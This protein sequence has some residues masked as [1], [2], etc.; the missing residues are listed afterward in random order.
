MEDLESRCADL[1][2][3]IEEEKIEQPQLTREQLTFWLERFRS[4]D[5]SDPKCRST[6]IDVFVSAV[7]VYDDHL[8]IVCNFTGEDGAVTYDFINDIESYDG[9]VEV[10]GFDTS[11]VTNGGVDEHPR[12]YVCSAMFVMLLPLT[13]VG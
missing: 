13:A 1:N 10:F 12:L 8:R 7:Y 5:F 9:A 4:G 6:F 3:A 2:I 11:W